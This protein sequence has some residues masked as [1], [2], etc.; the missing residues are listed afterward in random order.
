MAFEVTKQ[1]ILKQAIALN[2]L[3]KETRE[4]KYKDEETRLRRI[5]LELDGLSDLG[6]SGGGVDSIIAGDNITISPSGGTG[7]VTINAVTSST[8]RTVDSYNA[9]EGQSS[10]A[11]TASE[12]DFLDVY[13]NGARL[14]SSEYTVSGS[15]VILSSAAELDDEVIIISYDNSSVIDINSLIDN[16]GSVGNDLYLYYNY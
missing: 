9:S 13:L 8:L 2:K 3:W 5:A 11:I 14:I 15:N 4:Q 16:V 1:E 6:G 7:D 12:F 10:F